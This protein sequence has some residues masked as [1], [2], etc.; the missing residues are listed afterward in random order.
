MRK[1]VTLAAVLTVTSN[2]ALAQS[3]SVV[4]VFTGEVTYENSERFTVALANRVDTIVGVQVTV[5]PTNASSPDGYLVDGISD[6]GGVYIS[7][8]EGRMGGIQINARD[9]YWRHGS[10]VIDGFYVVKYGGMGQGIMGYQLQPV[11]E[12]AVRLSPARLVEVDADAI[13]FEAQAATAD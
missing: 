6:S 11:D 9:A 7:R 4:P 8:T 13:L 5:D 3:Q 10:Y 12:A 2:P 1:L